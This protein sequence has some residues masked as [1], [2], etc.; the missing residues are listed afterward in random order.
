VQL[1]GVGLSLDLV[2]RA[3]LVIDKL[4]DP[5][6]FHA[7]RGSTNSSNPMTRRSGTIERPSGLPTLFLSLLNF[8]LIPA[9]RFRVDF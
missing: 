5:V 9:V 6:R 2:G 8:S 1:G 7:G 4:E 3:S